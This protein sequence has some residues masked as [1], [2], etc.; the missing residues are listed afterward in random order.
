MMIHYIVGG[1]AFISLIGLV[2][3]QLTVGLSEVGI[4]N[5]K[6]FDF[7]AATALL[8]FLIYYAAIATPLLVL[9]FFFEIDLS[10]SNF[11]PLVISFAIVAPAY[12]FGKTNGVLHG[13]S[14]SDLLKMPG[15]GII[16]AIDRTLPSPSDR[17]RNS[18]LEL[19]KSYIQAI[20]NGDFEKIKSTPKD[21]IDGIFNSSYHSLVAHAAA[22][23]N[24]EIVRWLVEQGATLDRRSEVLKFAAVTS[25]VE[26]LAYLVE[27]GAEPIIDQNNWDEFSN[28]R[29][30]EPATCRSLPIW[31]AGEAGR[32]ENFRFL[33]E[34]ANLKTDNRF[35][36]YLRA[37]GETPKWL[38]ELLSLKP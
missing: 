13:I 17:E 36:D 10:S 5:E 21:L 31:K 29:A 37:C 7:S 34:R 23:K 38:D 30:V 11:L 33:L 2:I 32:V 19:R 12:I 26:I 16:I 28:G 14:I 25:S 15:F 35:G 8:N 20:E 4:L 6:T 24:I 1:L 18:K 27:R 3:A 9:R 22:A